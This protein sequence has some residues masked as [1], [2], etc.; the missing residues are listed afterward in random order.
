MGAK[1]RVANPHLL[2]RMTLQNTPQIL[3]GIPTPEKIQAERTSPGHV[4]ALERFLNQCLQ[5]LKTS[6]A[7]L[8]NVL[9]QR[10]VLF[11]PDPHQGIIYSSTSEQL[12]PLTRDSLQSLPL[13]PELMFHVERCPVEEL[14]PTPRTTRYNLKRPRIN[15]QYRKESRQ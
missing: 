15:R 5:Q 4:G 11:I 2:C 10:H 14:P 9:T 8:R 7:A 1:K 6:M 12:I 3:S 13:A